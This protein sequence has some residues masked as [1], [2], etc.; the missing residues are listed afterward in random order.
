MS[1]VTAMQ[2]QWGANLNS[3]RCTAPHL[4]LTYYFDGSLFSALSELDACFTQLHHTFGSAAAQ[5]LLGSMPCKHMPL[6]PSE[7]AYMPVE[8]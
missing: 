5:L 7:R 2:C 4:R 1:F 6:L 8:H 3:R